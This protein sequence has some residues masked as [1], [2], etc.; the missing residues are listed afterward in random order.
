MRLPAPRTLSLGVIAASL[1]LAYGVWY[2]YSVML[3]ALLEEFG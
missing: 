3:V 2:S 1:A